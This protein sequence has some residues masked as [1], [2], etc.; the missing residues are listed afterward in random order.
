MGYPNAILT[1]EANLRVLAVLE[2]LGLGSEE[3]LSS[4]ARIKRTELNHILLKLHGNR[5]VE[6]GPDFC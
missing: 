1:N 6:F 5:L 4:D 2:S 3:E